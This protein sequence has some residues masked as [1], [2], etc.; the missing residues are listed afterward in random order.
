MANIPFRIAAKARMVASSATSLKMPPGTFPLRKII[1][2][3]I[4]D[5]YTP[6]NGPFKSRLIIIGIPVKSHETTPG[7]KGKGMSKGGP[8]IASDA[9]ASA[10]SILANASFFVVS[11]CKCIP[12][13]EKK[14]D[15]C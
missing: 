15:I 9:A 10:P 7:R 11:F 8:L 14:Y 6:P 3:P 13:V 1:E 4:I 5:V 2:Q 12:P